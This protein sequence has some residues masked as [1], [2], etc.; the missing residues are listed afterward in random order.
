MGW[1]LVC[2]LPGVDAL[3]PPVHPGRGSL[4]K[5]ALGSCSKTTGKCRNVIWPNVS[6]VKSL[7]PASLGAM[8]GC[9]CVVTTHGRVTMQ[10]VL[11][12]NTIV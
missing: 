3:H 2:L 5:R 6:P 9:S 12:S 8:L 10:Q 7:I 11:L 4:V 1:P